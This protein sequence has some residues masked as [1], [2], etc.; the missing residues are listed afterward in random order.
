MSKEKRLLRIQVTNGT[1]PKVNVRVPLGLAKLA[2]IGGI[3]DALQKRD[4]DIDE[5]LDEIDD[6]P[7][8]KLVDVVDEKSGDHIEVYVETV[9][10]P[11]VSA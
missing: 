3:K 9:G 7:D 4:I 5:I 1:E 6:T 11:L 8:G 10:A 2:R